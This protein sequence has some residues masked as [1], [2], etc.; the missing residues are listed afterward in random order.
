LSLLGYTYAV[1]GQ[2]SKARKALNQLKQL[3]RQRYIKP[4]FIALIYIGL[5]EQEQALP[6]LERACKDRNE[7]ML[8]LKVDPRL[9]IIRVNPGFTR[10]LTRVGLDNNNRSR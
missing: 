5:A 1:A 2:R 3:S 4:A 9:D 6:W 10:L 7:L 8:M